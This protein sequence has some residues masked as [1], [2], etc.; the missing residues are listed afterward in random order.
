M[1]FLTPEIIAQAREHYDEGRAYHNWSHIEWMLGLFEEYRALVNDAD[2]FEV[3]VVGHDVIY[4]SRRHDNELL[5]AKMAMAWIAN[6][7]SPRQL[8]ATDKGIQASAT[9]IVPAGLP[10][11]VASDV[12]LF[13]DMD[14]SILGSDDRTFKAYDEA[15][16][17][18]YSWATDEQWKVGRAAVMKKFL[19]RPSI[20]I[21]PQLKERFEEPA[22]SNLKQLIEA[23][24]A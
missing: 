3:K 11:A 5:S 14:L 15:I 12:A 13:L 17:E 20:F 21:T 22:R 1:S 8:D 6:V 4:D 2:V 23:L 10:T 16:R 18:E 7:A 9:H 24:E 19:T